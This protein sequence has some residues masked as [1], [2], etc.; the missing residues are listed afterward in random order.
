M[1]DIKS[2]LFDLDGTLID[3]YDI[4]NCSMRHTIEHFCEGDYTDDVLMHGV[5]TPLWNQMLH[6]AGG[7]GNEAQADEMTA[8]YRQHNDAIH[9]ERA[10]EFP[11][12]A[13]MMNELLQAGYRI[14]VVTGKRHELAVR[15]LRLFGLL[16]KVEFVLGSDDCAQHKPQPGPILDGC[17][18]LGMDPR[19]CAYV[20]DSPYDIAAANA[21]GCL[22]VAV[23]W[24]MFPLEQLLEQ[25]PDKVIDAPNQLLDVL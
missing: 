22:S 19:A 8:F 5:G 9:D 6:F 15:G 11:G 20:G 12:V 17:R 1:S 13:A 18:K 24:G 7:P 23:T 16:E 25:Q 14:G 2:V 21:A 4:I 10:R 3:T